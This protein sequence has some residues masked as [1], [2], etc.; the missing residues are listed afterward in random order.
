[1]TPG[2]ERKPEEAMENYIVRIYR[3]DAADPHKVCGVFQSVERQTENT[4]NDLSSLMS[5]LATPDVEPVDGEAET[6]ATSE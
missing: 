1:M 2:Q 4:F 5:L 6:L 3:R